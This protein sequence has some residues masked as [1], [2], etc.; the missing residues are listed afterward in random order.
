MDCN[1]GGGQNRKERPLG[2]PTASGS[3]RGMMEGGDSAKPSLK[4]GESFALTEGGGDMQG[5]S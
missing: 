1:K 4:Q 2:D 3:P 5:T